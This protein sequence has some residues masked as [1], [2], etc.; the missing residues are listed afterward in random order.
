MTTTTPP[1][2]KCNYLNRRRYREPIN[3]CNEYNSFGNKHS[4]KYVCVEDENGNVRKIKKRKWFNSK[5]CDKNDDPYDQEVDVDEN[6]IIDY[7]C[8]YDDM[9]VELVQANCF[10]SDNYWEQT[11]V[12]L[13]TCIKINND[14]N[15]LYIQ[16]Y[17]TFTV[18]SYYDTFSLYLFMFISLVS[19]KLKFGSLVLVRTLRSTKCEI[20]LFTPSARY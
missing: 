13:R 2:T 7:E 3:Q 4:Y 9:D 17:T 18:T 1:D 19:N 15:S 14:T 11:S 6:I 8:A 5:S 16:C 20:L 12:I 10:E